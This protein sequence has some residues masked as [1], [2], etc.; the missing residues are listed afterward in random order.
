VPVTIENFLD[1]I[2][3]LRI[4]GAN[5]GHVFEQATI[6]SRINQYS[7]CEFVGIEVPGK[8]LARI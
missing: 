1:V 8:L 7:H 4:C 5:P 2:E 6:L 3:T